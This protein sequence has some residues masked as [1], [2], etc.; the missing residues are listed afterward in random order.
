MVGPSG[1]TSPGGKYSRPTWLHGRPGRVVWGWSHSCGTNWVREGRQEKM[2]Q[3]KTV[4]ELKLMVATLQ[5]EIGVLQ[6][7]LARQKSVAHQIDAFRQ[8]AMDSR[9]ALR[10]R[11]AKPFPLSQSAR[12]QNPS[13]CYNQQSRKT[14]PVVTTSRVPKPFPLLQLAG[15]NTE[16]G[17]SKGFCLSIHKC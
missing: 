13:H 15:S 9:D 6:A 3:T 4:G 11:L 10:V 1:S 2:G 7:S 5:K 12:S 16:I 14:L 17:S 8:E